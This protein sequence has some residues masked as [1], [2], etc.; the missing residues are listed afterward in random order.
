MKVTAKNITTLSD[1]VHTVDKNLYLKVQKGRRYYIFR[2]TDK[3]GK[4]RDVSLGPSSDLPLKEAKNIAA[5]YRLR[6]LKG[7]PF[8]DEEPVVKAVTVQEFFKSTVE[9]IISVTKYKNESSAVRLRREAELYIYPVIGKTEVS[10]VTR[11]DILAVLKPIWYEKPIVAKEVLSVLKRVLAYAVSDGV[12]SFNPAVWGGNLDMFLPKRS[13]VYAAAHHKAASL[14]DIRDLFKEDYSSPSFASVLFGVLTAARRVEFS[15]AKWGEID[16]NNKV[17]SVPAE[18]RK[19][20][21]PY[22]HRVPLSEQAIGLLNSLERRSEFIFPSDRINDSVQLQSISAFVHRIS[23]GR[24]TMHGMRSAFRDWCA[25][26]GVPDILAEKS[27]MHATGNAVVQAYQ[28]SDL[29]EQRREVMQKWADAVCPRDRFVL[30]S[31][32]SD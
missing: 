19:D 10:S 2:Y 8:K 11:D 15:P 24:Y 12:L 29:L 32:A 7:L 21:K 22:P 5:E 13:K 14:S 30:D 4:R 16:F 17:W 3:A 6:L 1:G 31:P 20:G 18:R 28:R 26:N 9:T 25:E 23:S 27:L